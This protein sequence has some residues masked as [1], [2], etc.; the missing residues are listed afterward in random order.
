MAE[1]IDKII[2]AYSRI[3]YKE[4]LKMTEEAIKYES[5]SL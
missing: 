4:A 3:S 2:D 1:V 5:F